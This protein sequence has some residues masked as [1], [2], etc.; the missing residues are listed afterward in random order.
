MAKTKTGVNRSEAIREAFTAL[1]RAKAKEIVAYLKEKGVEVTVGL[2]YQV[3][4]V[5]KKKKKLGAKPGFQ[6][7]AVLSPA[8]KSVSAL[9]RNGK[10]GVGASITLVKATAAKVG[11]FVALKEIVDALA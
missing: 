8:S 1:P 10:L 4:K 7:K 3:K 11:G 9:S 6:V 5:S 2:V